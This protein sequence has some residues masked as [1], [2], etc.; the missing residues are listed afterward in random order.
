MKRPPDLVADIV[1][2]EGRRCWRV[3]GAIIDWLVLGHLEALYRI[4]VWSKQ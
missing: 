3:H 2:Y 1:E 4:N